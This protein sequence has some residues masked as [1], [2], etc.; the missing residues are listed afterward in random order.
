MFTTSAFKA[1][2]LLLL[3]G[4]TVAS[5]LACPSQEPVSCA[6]SP[7]PTGLC[8]NDSFLCGT[9][10]DF[11]ITGTCAGGVGGTCADGLCCSANGFCGT[12]DEY[13]T[14]PPAATPQGAC[15]GGIGGT[16]AD[17]LCC[18][19]HGFCGTGVDYCGA[20]STTPAQPETGAC[21]GGVGGTCAEG[22]C[23]SAFGFCGTGTDYCGSNGAIETGSAEPTPAPTSSCNAAAAPVVKAVRFAQCGGNGFT[24]STVCEDPY[25]CVVSSEWYSQCI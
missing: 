9:G 6:V 7:C 16:C 5:P 18:S 10:P 22:L 21:E 17:G 8:C 19:S 13:C 25:K 15:E 20:N 24:G 11:C 2:S 3:V 14:T 1:L 23:C 12:G 4:S